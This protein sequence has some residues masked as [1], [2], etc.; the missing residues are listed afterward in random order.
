MDKVRQKLHRVLRMVTEVEVEINQVKV[1]APK[2]E[3]GK[4]IV[5][6]KSYI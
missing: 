3:A 6:D 1:L 5:N 4:E 2:P